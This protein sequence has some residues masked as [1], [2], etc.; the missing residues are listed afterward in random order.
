[1]QPTQGEPV[2]ERIVADKGRLVSGQSLQKFLDTI[3]ANQQAN[4]VNFPQ[5]YA[6][7][8]RIDECFVRAG[9]NL[10]NPK[11]VITGNLLLRC[12]YAFK[13]GAGMAL[14]GQVV[15]VFVMLRS[16]L[17][18]AGYCLTIYETPA[19]ENVFIG[20][21]MSAS[22]M[23]AQKEAFKI[24]A[25]RAAIRRHDEKLAEL[26]DDLYQRSIDFGGHPNPHGSFSA[27]VLDDS[28]GEAG[29]TTLA[30]SNDPTTLAHALKNTAQVGLTALHIL[31]HVFTAKFE[32]LGIRHDLEVLRNIGTV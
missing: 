20:R 3:H 31:Q 8:E 6:I 9:K 10:T 14:A 28:G 15:E 7:I 13:T 4:R 26:F 24:S 25:I 22:E 30:I 2:R 5:W 18:Y 21:H 32:L 23:R 16:A 1:M 29:M 11:P 27:M 19:L 12:Q 17:E